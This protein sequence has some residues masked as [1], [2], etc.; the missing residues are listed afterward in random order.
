MS[1]TLK[2]VRK[3]LEKIGAKCVEAVEWRKSVVLTGMVDTWEEKI[4]AGMAAAGKG[5]KGVVND[6]E[7]RGIR[8]EAMSI[9]SYRDS[10][11]EGKHFD[12]V[13][14]GGGITGS[15][16]ARELSRYDVT[17]ARLEKEEDLARHASSRNDGM[18]HDGFAAKPGTK[19]AAYNVR[20]NR[21]YTKVTEELGVEFY[22]P[23]SMILFGCPFTRL[24]VP[25]MKAR[26]KKNGVDGYQYLTRKEVA[27][28]E[29]NLVD[30]QHG[31]FFLPSAGVLSPY[32]MVLA[33]AENAAENGADIVLGCAVS[34]FEIRDGAVRAVKTNRGMCTAGVVVNAAG[35]W[36]DTVAGFADDRF[37]SHHGRKGVDAILDLRTGE[38]QSTIAAMPP[39]LQAKSKTKGGGLIMTPEGNI[40]VG[41]TAK[42]V[43]GRE[44]YSTDP[45]DIDELMHHINLNRK[46]KR[47]DIIT[48]FAGIR[49]CTY[50]EDFIIESSEH[51]AN[52][53]HVAGIQSPGLASA[54]AIAEDV[55]RMAVDIL[56]KKMEVRQNP[57][58]NPIR[59][60]RPVLKGMPLEQRAELIRQNPAYGRI[61]CRCEEISEGEIRDA[62]R[63]KVRPMTLDGI[64]RRARTGAGRCQGGFCTPRVLEIMAEELSLD[65]TRLTK[66]GPES[67]LFFGYTKDG[68]DYREAG[69]KKFEAAESL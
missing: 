60:P 18:I 16:I 20:G 31:A 67:E 65:I 43:P 68:V 44:D 25:L 47:S 23:G 64:K 57:R 36:A 48:Y 45:E 42:E 24:A 21:M 4:D 3:A 12:V 41:P 13:I 17:I 37:F 34:G 35:I 69:V 58:F 14:I 1:D 19:K 27:R 51:V 63:S 6:I 2:R 59:R 49:A 9:P 52:L 10:H 30:K 56:R 66:K 5:Y 55:C 8:V 50:E 61:V 32:K 28:R 29:P 62:L 11:L 38:Y 7:V 22:R 53:V 15:A 39:L 33:Y 26:A 40:L 46:L 54:P